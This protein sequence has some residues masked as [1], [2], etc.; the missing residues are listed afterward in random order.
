[1]VCVQGLVTSILHS[2]VVLASL[3][4]TFV[5]GGLDPW[6]NGASSDAYVSVWRVASLSRTSAF[7]SVGP[8][9]YPST[10]LRI[11]RQSC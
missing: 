10:L 9:G 7:I 3:L 11:A 6:A 2:A 5:H 8:Q 4:M 1:M